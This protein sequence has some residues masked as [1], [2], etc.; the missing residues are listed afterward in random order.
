M[1]KPR[2]LP[3]LALCPDCGEPAFS[4]YMVKGDLWRA[5]AGD[6]R[7]Q[8]IH[9]ACFEKRLGRRLRP[10]DLGEQPINDITRALLERLEQ[11][12]SPC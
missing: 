3:H 10:T 11:Q 7:L 12:E 4:T 6:D 8:L 1:I 5:V 9:L 2:P